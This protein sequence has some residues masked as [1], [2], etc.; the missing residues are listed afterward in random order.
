VDRRRQRVGPVGLLR[1]ELIGSLGD[2]GD[3]TVVA[4]ARRRF[5]ARQSDADA[6]P[7]Q[8]HDTI[9]MVVAHHA[10]EATW[11]AIR[12]EAQARRTRC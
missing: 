11:N 7:A 5:A 10:D 9:L 1:Q 8:L 4:E 6:V 3:P 12:T 2:L